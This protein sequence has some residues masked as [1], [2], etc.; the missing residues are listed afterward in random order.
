MTNIGGLRQKPWLASYNAYEV[1]EEERYL[2]KSIRSWQFINQYIKDPGMA[3]G[4]GEFMPIIPS[5]SR[6]I[7]QVFGNAHIIMPGPAWN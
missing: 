4:F 5:W 6:M 7:R 3:S 2:K 1:S